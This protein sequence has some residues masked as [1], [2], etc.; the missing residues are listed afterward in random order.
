MKKFIKKLTKKTEGFTLVELI[1]VIAI[2]GILAGVAVPAYTGYLNKAEEAADTQSLAA[3]YTAAAAAL[4][5]EG[6]TVTSITVTDGVVTAIT[7]APAE[8]FADGS[9]F[10]DYMAGNT[11]ATDLDASYASGK[12]TIG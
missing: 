6:K 10:M 11:L 5:Q 12:W 1:V 3:V 9:D 8:G 7:P 2:L 4:A